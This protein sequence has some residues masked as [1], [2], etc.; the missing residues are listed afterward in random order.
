[1]EVVACVVP[2]MFLKITVPLTVNGSS[3]GSPNSRFS[4]I[5][6]AVTVPTTCIIKPRRKMT[7]IHVLYIMRYSLSIY[8]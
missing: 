1:M 8:I 3:V 6:V 7:A 5:T 4:V 2:V